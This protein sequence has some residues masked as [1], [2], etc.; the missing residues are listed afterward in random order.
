MIVIKKQ[1]GMIERDSVCG[2]VHPGST[3]VTL[4]MVAPIQNKVQGMPQADLH[5]VASDW[6]L[7]GADRAESPARRT[8]QERPDR[9]AAC[10]AP[11]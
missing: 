8:Y 1:M 11:G 7:A 2:L 9:Q 5:A 3:V 6:G 10:T 4:A